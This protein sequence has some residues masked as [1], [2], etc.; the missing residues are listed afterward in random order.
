MPIAITASDG[1]YCHTGLATARPVCRTW[2]T[3]VQCIIDFSL[4]GLGANPWIKVD[5]KETDL[6]TFWSTILLNLSPCVNP[7]PRYPLPNPA[8]KQWMTTVTIYPQ[9]AYRHVG[10]RFWAPNFIREATLNF[11]RIF[12]NLAHS[13]HVAKFG[14]VL[15]GK[16]DERVDDEKY[17]KEMTQNDDSENSQF[18]IRRSCVTNLHFS[19]NRQRI[20]PIDQTCAIWSIVLRE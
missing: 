6:V 11:G 8:V 12:A 9:H 20:W 18:C 14:R 7:R 16:T 1:Q 4:L 2:L 5:Q 3:T 13:Q 10:I 19:P 15:F 17:I